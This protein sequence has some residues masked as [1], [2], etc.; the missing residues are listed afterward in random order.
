MSDET[1]KE[2][3]VGDA[4]ATKDAGVAL[5][6]DELLCRRMAEAVSLN[7]K[8]DR[9]HIAMSYRRKM[10]KVLKKR[11][12]A[13]KHQRK[14]GEHWVVQCRKR[15]LE[16]GVKKENVVEGLEMEGVCYK[17]ALGEDLEFF[18]HCEKD[19]S[20]LSQAITEVAVRETLALNRCY[21]AEYYNERMTNIHNEI[22]MY[23]NMNRALSSAIDDINVRLLELSSLGTYALGNKHEA[24][25]IGNVKF[26]VTHNG[27][28]LEECD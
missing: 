22:C 6:S 16:L 28:I 8:A 3:R 27:Q 5:L 1:S 7:L 20:D 25:S 4:A 14:Q 18:C 9:E 12:C 15:L 26:Y 21:A 13:Y 11:K 10:E 19:K 17:P 2:V 24:G 23:E